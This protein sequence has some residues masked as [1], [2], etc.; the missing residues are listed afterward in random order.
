MNV[1]SSSIHK[2][3]LGLCPS[4]SVRHV[5]GGLSLVYTGALEVA[6]VLSSQP[7]PHGFLGH[8]IGHAEVLPGISRGRGLACASPSKFLQVM[9]D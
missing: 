6:D 1:N 3:I 2:N 5:F 7:S 9:L 8:I 4:R